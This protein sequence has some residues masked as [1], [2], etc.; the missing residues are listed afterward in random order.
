M[1]VNSRTQELM[2]CVMSLGLD[3]NFRLSTLLNQ[4]TKLRGRIEL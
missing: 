3:I 4:M 1:E 2:I